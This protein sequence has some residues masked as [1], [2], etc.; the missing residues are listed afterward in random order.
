MPFL[1]SGR[2]GE[3]GSSDEKL[4]HFRAR[5]AEQQELL[6]GVAL[7]FE[8]INLLCKGRD[9]VLTSHREKL[10]EIIQRGNNAIKDAADLLSQARQD[11]SKVELLDAFS[12]PECRGH[13]HPVELEA[14]ARHLVA[15]YDDV[16][17]NRPR[18]QAFTQDEV[19]RLVEAAA[20]TF[21]NQP[22]EG[23]GLSLKKRD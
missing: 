2:K 16:F 17:P 5:I 1:K 11:R 22:R 19:M 12:F 8:G 6:Y 14:R 4:E 9:A 23:D 20:D 7:F 3:D 15:I 10:S 21:S 13:E 18:G